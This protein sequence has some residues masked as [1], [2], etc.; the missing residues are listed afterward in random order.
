MTFQFLLTDF[1]RLNRALHRATRQLPRALKAKP[2]LHRFRIAVDHM[3][4]AARRSGN[5]HT[6]TV[7]AQIQRRI[8]RAR[9]ERFRRGALNRFQGSARTFGTLGRHCYAL[10]FVLASNYAAHQP[11]ARGF[12]SH[13]N[14]TNPSFACHRG[15]SIKT[16]AHFGA[17]NLGKCC[18]SLT[19]DKKPHPFI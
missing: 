16:H 1:Q 9:I 19:H 7:R 17:T 15:Q 18:R 8:Q 12:T 14:V 11:S 6:A 10:H 13:T 5:Q 4:L 2:E 3:K